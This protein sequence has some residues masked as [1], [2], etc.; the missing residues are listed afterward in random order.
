MSAFQTRATVRNSIDG[1][2]DLGGDRTLL[3]FLVWL[4]RVIV[5]LSLSVC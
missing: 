2:N 1:L 3:S 5:A 4:A